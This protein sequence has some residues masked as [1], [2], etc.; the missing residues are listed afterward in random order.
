MEENKKPKAKYNPTDIQKKAAKRVYDSFDVMVTVR[1]NTYSEFNSRTLKTFVDDGDKRLDA[2]VPDRKS[3]NPP[4]ED[5]Q[6]N[7][8]APTIRDKQVKMLASFSMQVPDMDTKVFGDDMNIDINRAETAKWLIKGSYLQEQNIVIQNF[9]EA[10]ECASHGTTIVYEGYL[11]TKYKQK[12]I[13]TYDN[14]TGKIEVGEREVTVDDKCISFI[15][16]ITEFYMRSAY[17]PDIQDQADMAWVRYVDKDIFDYEFGQYDNA[18]FVHEKGWFVDADTDTFY[19]RNKWAN[20]VVKDNQVEV[21]RYYN[22]LTDE[23]I[24]IAN[25][26]VLLIAPLLWAVNGVKQFPF[27]KTIWQPFSNIKFFYG[28]SFPNLMSG[29]ADVYDTLLNTMLDKQYRSMVPGMLIGRVNQDALDLEDLYITGTTRISVE[30]VSQVKPIPVAGVDNGDVMMLKI[31]AS[32]LD[33]S[34][35]SL[36]TMMANKQATAREI[37]L[38]DEKLKELKNIHFEMMTDLWRQKYTLRFAN[39]Q[40][41]YP[42]P[43]TT[44][45]GGKDVTIY[46]TFIIENATLNNISGETG[47]L[48]VQFRNVKPQEKMDAQKEISIEEEKMKLQG[49]NYK[50]I[51]VPT[52]YFDNRRINIEVQSAS[53]YKESMGRQQAIVLEKLDYIGKYFPQIFVLNQK[54][55]FKQMSSAYGDKPEKY[56]SKLDQFEKAK[57]DMAGA[58]SGGQGMPAPTSQTVP[59]LHAPAKA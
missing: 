39:I 20:R 6:S 52:D 25:G 53:I 26:V 56:L 59:I 51:I 1:N 22:R 29:Q 55:Y 50:K 2:Y 19:Y 17:V 57:E 54:E 5:W 30:D 42:Q 46:R 44:V 49:I 11:K 9:W 10:W 15:V 34:S 36:P 37:V 32:S 58:V 4:K 45:E 13:K 38:A 14:V 18:E 41:N 47:I 43:R 31:I 27:A 40:I 23:Y 21:I 35:P 16:P 12:S 3:Y 48:A 7:L 8:S 28:N 24:I 33:E